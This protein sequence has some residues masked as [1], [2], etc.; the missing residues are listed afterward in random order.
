V[1][2]VG[3]F[4]RLF[5]AYAWAQLVSV[6]LLV[7]AIGVML[8]VMLLCG[9]TPWNAR[10]RTRVWALMILLALWS[11]RNLSFFG[12]DASIPPPWRQVVHYQVT[13]LFLLAIAWF[14]ASWTGLGQGH[15]RW[16]VLGALGS[17]LACVATGLGGDNALVFKLLFPLESLLSF[18]LVGI[19]LLLFVRYAADGD[20]WSRYEAILFMV[21]LTA[22]MVDAVDDR[23]DISL[24]L[25]P[26]WPLTFY[27]APVCGLLLALGSCAVLVG[28]SQRAR[29]MLESMNS[30]MDLRLGEQARALME[31][32]TREQSLV[33]EQAVFAERQRL[34]RD[35]HDGLGGHLVS[36][37]MRLRSGPLEAKQAAR[38][39]SRALDDLRLIVVSL[40]HA[41][42][43]LGITL[44]SFR[45]RFEP[46]IR[47]AGLELD[48]II[49]PLAGSLHLPAEQMLHLLR[50]LQ[51]ATT[52]SLRHAGACRLTVALRCA[53][54][55]GVSLQIE[56]DG[57]GI[58]PQAIPGKGL[59]NMR[60]RAERIGAGL[61]IDS[62]SRGT[63]ITILLQTGVAGQDRT[64]TG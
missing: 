20:G 54:G 46:R 19:A 5:S 60:H 7:A 15:G 55:G 63:R 26:D 13:F 16:Y 49:E 53:A 56:D 52:N 27:A 61:S 14:A 28:Q 32:H 11:L 51:E 39:V 42:E 50:M 33:R 31:A 43:S 18:S 48:W 58:P 30:L 41:G 2:F 1:F 62:D 3:E 47:D 37:L 12:F 57:A 36:L 44:G 8:F 9:L 29:T 23:Y 22:V 24:P 38:D 10:D 21:C 6:D 25:L 40:D 45:E 34:M 35:M 17:V 64:V 59:A 4:D